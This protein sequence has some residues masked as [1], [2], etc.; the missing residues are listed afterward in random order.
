M[1]ELSLRVM[2]IPY[3]LLQSDLRKASPFLLG[4]SLSDEESIFYFSKSDKI[5]PYSNKKTHLCLS[6]RA[7]P[8]FRVI[9]KIHTK[10][11]SAF[12]P[13]R[14]T[15]KLESAAS[16]SSTSDSFVKSCISV[17]NDSLLMWY[18]NKNRG[19]RNVIN[20]RES[21]GHFFFEDNSPVILNISWKEIPQLCREN[22]I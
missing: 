14:V 20:T 22:E 2:K 11:L 9:R 4:L 15:S 8:Q 1:K 12:P 18:Y 5:F 16:T 10:V 13:S 6:I 3:R 7:K 21:I 19:F 17:D